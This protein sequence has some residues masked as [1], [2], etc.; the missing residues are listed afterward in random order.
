LRYQRGLFLPEVGMSSLDKLAREARADEIF[1]HLLR[2]H[3]NKNR[4][5]SDRPNAPTY[6]PT[7]FA[8]EAEA[9]KH[10]LRKSELEE[11]MQRLFNTDKIAVENYG[12]PSRPYYRLVL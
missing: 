7:V 12:R 5:V 6:A 4:N 8:R 3:T 10:H 1:L 2:E 11:A 9:K